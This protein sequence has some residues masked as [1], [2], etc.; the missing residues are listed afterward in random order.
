M[1]VASSNSRRPCVIKSLG[2]DFAWR[3]QGGAGW[4]A[5][6]GMWEERGAGQMNNGRNRT[7]ETAGEHCSS[8]PT[9][10][11]LPARDSLEGLVYHRWE[12]NQL[13]THTINGGGRSCPRLLLL[14]R[15]RL[16]AYFIDSRES[17]MENVGWPSL[18][19]LAVT[20]CLSDRS[21]RSHSEWRGGAE[22]PIE[23]AS[24]LREL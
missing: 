23:A 9:F 19:L 12:T 22:P 10:S 3:A 5:R 14:P 13:E 17:K 20:S 15:T 4:G 11:C 1:H 7:S 21:I 2:R 6:E 24:S 16:L 18:L 8:A